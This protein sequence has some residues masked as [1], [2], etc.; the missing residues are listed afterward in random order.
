M[1]V[2]SCGVILPALVPSGAAAQEQATTIAWQ[3]TPASK[4]KT[5]LRNVV[6]AQERYHAERGSYASGLQALEVEVES[7]IRVQIVAAGADGWQAKA[8]YQARPG[9]SC[10][11]FV[12]T[13]GET[14]PP[15]TDGDREMA[16]EPGVPLCDRMR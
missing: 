15:R 16:G 1:W 4:L 5:M 10:V 2:L 9:K 3:A 13:V 8:T 11:V 12:G 6:A 7:G 14:A